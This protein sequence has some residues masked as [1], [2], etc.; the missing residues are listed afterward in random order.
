MGLRGCTAYMCGSGALGSTAPVLPRKGGGSPADARG[1]RLSRIRSQVLSELTRKAPVR[2]VG[3]IAA[4]GSKRSL[5]SAA[6]TSGRPQTRRRR[7]DGQE[8][9]NDAP[10]RSFAQRS[11]RGRTPVFSVAPSTEAHPSA[12]S[13]TQGC[14]ELHPWV[15]LG[16]ARQPAAF[17]SR[18]CTSLHK[19]PLLVPRCWLA[20][21]VHHGARRPTRAPIPGSRR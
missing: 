10:S 13:C 19:R 21:N 1:P 12:V 9:R 5:A 7:S 11:C 15:A 20:R 6:A 18:T 3:V 16:G 4:V 8:A 14:M 17:C 2:P